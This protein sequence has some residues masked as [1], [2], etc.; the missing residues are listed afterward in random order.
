MSGIGVYSHYDSTGTCLYV[1]MTGN[2][3]QRNAV[4]MS[5][6]EWRNQIARIEFIECENLIEASLKERDLIRN[7]KPIHNILHAY[8][9]TDTQL[10]ELH[11][12]FTPNKFLDFVKESFGFDENELA[13]FLCTTIE[14]LRIIRLRLT[15]ITWPAKHYICEVVNSC[16]Y[17]LDRYLRK[18]SPQ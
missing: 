7:L 14:H 4:H 3:K 18:W 8:L 10:E 9:P 12:V 15:G 11:Y 1:G 17:D 16:G 5:V 2:M 6:T 13:M